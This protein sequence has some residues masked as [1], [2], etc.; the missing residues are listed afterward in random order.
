MIP[1]G[2]CVLRNAYAHAL[3]QKSGIRAAGEDLN[4]WLAVNTTDFYNAISLF[5]G[6]LEEFCTRETCPT[7][8]AG[9]KYEY[10]W[11]DGAKFKK[12]TQMS[13]P[14]YME[15]LF[16]WVGTQLDDPKIFPQQF[17]APFPADFK[18][19]VKN[20]YKR[21]FRRVAGQ[22][23]SAP[24][25]CSALTP[26]RLPPA[27]AAGCLGTCT[28]VTSGRSAIWG[29]KSISTRPPSTLSCLH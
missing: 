21:L 9:P 24:R 17:G 16:D 14:Q 8:N 4:E 2:A 13:A 11:A 27:C 10:L 1:E 15:C 28:T 25:F 12:P 20:I 19:V 22:E 23:L 18:D 5:Y 26:R 29:C 7:M 3:F 6:A